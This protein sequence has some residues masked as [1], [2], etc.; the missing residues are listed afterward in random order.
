M[1]E[2]PADSS[3]V[4]VQQDGH[5]LILRIN[6]PDAMNALDGRVLFEC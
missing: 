6:R 4:D 3:P 5:V 1:P 2:Q